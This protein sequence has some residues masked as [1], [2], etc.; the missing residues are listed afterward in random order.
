MTNVKQAIEDLKNGKL[1]VLI[2]DDDREAEGDLVG[3]AKD[4]TPENINFVIKNARGLIC[5]PV[6]GD[7]A[8]RL[9]FK[10]MAADGSEDAFGTAFLTGVDH[11]QTT[12]G[13]SAYDRSITI[14]AI[15]SDTAQP[16]DF[17]KPGHVFPLRARQNG[18][19]ERQGHTEASIELA[20][21][22]G[23]DAAYI[24]EI[25]DD[26]GHMARKHRLFQKATEWGLTAI[27]IAD[28]ISYLHQDVV[29]P[30]VTVNLPNQYGDFKLSLFNKYDGKD[31]L[32]LT[33]GDLSQP[34]D[35]VPLI[36]VHSECLTGDVLGSHRCDCGEQLDQAM[37][38]IADYGYGAVIYLRQEG[39]GI[40]LA[41]KLMAYQ[42]QEAGLDTV[43]ANLELGFEADERNYDVAA[44]ILKFFGW[45]QVKLLT[46][47]PEKD[48]QLEA[49]GIQI[50]ER[51]PLIV[52][53]YPENKNYL[54]TK[55]ERF[56][57]AL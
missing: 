4:A 54:K 27:T 9:N 14:Q 36:R 10:P 26:D 7:K 5:V 35:K 44:K 34:S 18:L 37:K 25:V 23:T 22:A 41:N 2:D 17:Y 49:D 39:R 15:G 12:T 55:R 33:Y 30:T 48:S 13:I 3:L 28:L 46:N 29:E 8:D 21:L 1:I 56:N 40:G 51:L 45:D 24:C 32:A 38:E 57:H 16:N 53:V 6:T 42:L 52:N 11:K 43:D 19:A 47:N 20:Q 31:H 50:V